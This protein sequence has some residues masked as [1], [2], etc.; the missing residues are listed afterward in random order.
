MQA[1][2][3]QADMPVTTRARSYAEVNVN[4]PREYWDY[5]CHIVGWGEIEDYQLIRKIG[6]GKYS[7]VRFGLHAALMRRTRLIANFAGV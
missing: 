2:Q 5:E 4:K 3:Q 6:R 7:E 1:Q